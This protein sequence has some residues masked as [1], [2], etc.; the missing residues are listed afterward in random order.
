MPQIRVV[1]LDILTDERE[2]VQKWDS[3]VYTDCR[4]KEVEKNDNI[5]YGNAD[6][7]HRRNC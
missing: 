1:I 7:N 3:D 5:Y 2:T 4:G 6:Q